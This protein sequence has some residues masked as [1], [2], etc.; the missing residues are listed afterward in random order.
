[1]EQE[2]EQRARGSTKIPGEGEKK[3][4]GGRNK[5]HPRSI[6]VWPAPAV[7]P[8]RLAGEIHASTADSPRRSTS[9]SGGGVGGGDT[10]FT[11]Y[12]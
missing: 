4:R 1:M 6:K 3:A 11:S 12:R 2:A 5:T 7:C 10:V 8:L 9:G